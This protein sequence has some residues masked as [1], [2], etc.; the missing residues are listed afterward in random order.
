MNI[1]VTGHTGFLG[2]SFLESLVEKNHDINQIILVS[3]EDYVT[4]ANQ[5]KTN[6]VVSKLS[7]EYDVVLETQDTDLS[8]NPN[9]VSET[10]RAFT[11]L[12]SEP[13]HIINFGS[14]SH[15][16]R[17]IISPRDTVMNNVGIMLSILDWVTND[18]AKMICDIKLDH[19]STDEVYGSLCHIWETFSLHNHICPNNPYSVS[20]TTQEHLIQ[21]Y[22]NT[23]G[24]FDYRIYRLSNQFGEYQLEEKMIPRSISRAAKGK[25]IEVHGDGEHMRQWSYAPKTMEYLFEW[26]SQKDYNIN[27]VH[28][29]DSGDYAFMTN[30]DL[31]RNYLLPALKHCGVDATYDH[32]ND[33]PGND[34]AYRLSSE[35]VYFEEERD[36]YS[37]ML[38]T[39]EKILK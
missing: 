18:G 3:Q 1:Y 10:I 5:N 28:I 29:A 14:Q 23:F 13:I 11:D 36:F 38:Q 19:I 6:Q 12:G 37:M 22:H 17:S 39:V 33:R 21:A 26:I 34:K 35:Y 24:G 8:K 30:N 9:S 7:N 31:V 16:D 20:K 4:K 2:L 15:V 27:K 32:I 25:P